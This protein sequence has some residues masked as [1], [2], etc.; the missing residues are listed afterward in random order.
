MR[1]AAKKRFQNFRPSDC[2]YCGKWI[3]CDIIC[4][5]MCLHIIWIWASCGG[6]RCRGVPCG[7]ACHRTVWTMSGGHTMCHRISSRL[8]WRSFSHHG[9]SGAIFGWMLSNPA[10]WG[11]STDVLLFSD[12]HLS[13]VHHYRVFKLGLP[14]YAFRR[15]YLTC[16]RVFVAQCD[17]ASPVPGSS[18]SLRHARPCDQSDRF[19]EHVTS[20]ADNASP[21][22]PMTTNLASVT[23]YK[24][25]IIQNHI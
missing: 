19:H 2:S 8:V 18:V 13:L 24:Y 17:L 25:K 15:D 12:I 23:P 14:H 10:I 4:T 21:R 3:K 20:A 5:A 1:A 16:L 11:V 6:A 7:R 22:F 9:L